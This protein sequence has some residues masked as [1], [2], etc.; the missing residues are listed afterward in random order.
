MIGKAS[1]EHPENVEEEYWRQYYAALDSIITGIKEQFERKDYEMYATFEQF[2][3]KAI[4]GESFEEELQKVTDFYHD[5]FN[6]ILR[7]QLRTFSAVIGQGEGSVNTFHDI[8]ILVKHFKKPIRNLIGEVVKM[9]KL[10]IIMPGSNAVSERFSSSMR[11]LYTYLRTSMASSRLNNAMVLHIHK[12][13]LDKLLM[14]DVANDFVF[15]SDRRK[16]CLED[17]MMLI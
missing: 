5:D 14:V 8:W 10:V 16:T 3:I 1:D 11:R 13:R 15:E 9:I 7:V 2:L 4:L 6:D 17:L 12:D